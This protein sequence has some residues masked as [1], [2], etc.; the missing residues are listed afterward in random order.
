MADYYWVGDSG[1]WSDYTNHWS[2]TSGG[3]PAIYGNPPTLAD[4][5]IFDANSFGSAN[6][7]VN[8]DADSF[9][10]VVRADSV[11]DN[12]TFA[13]TGTFY[14]GSAGQAELTLGTHGWDYTGDIYFVSTGG[15]L[16]SAGNTVNNAI[17]VGVSGT[18]AELTL[19]DNINVGYLTLQEGVLEFNNKNVTALGLGVS[20]TF[21]TMNFGSGTVNTDYVQANPGTVE[22]NLGT[23]N[24]TVT[25]GSVSTG[26]SMGLDANGTLNSGSSNVYLTGDGVLFAGGSQTY[27][28]IYFSGSAIITGANTFNYLELGAGKTYD[29]EAEKT[30]TLNTVSFDGSGTADETVIRSY[31]PDTQFTFSKSSGTIEAQYVNLKDSNATGGALFIARDSTDSGNNSGWGFGGFNTALVATLGMADSINYTTFSYRGLTL[32]K[33]PHIGKIINLQPKVGRKYTYRTRS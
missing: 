14:L 7:T 18:P 9:A 16:T 5:A 22:I 17:Y 25:G 33:K 12:P 24:I 29:F 15:A 1:D 4:W 28:N 27:N 8:I 13:G 23:A 3:S 32:G 6:G 21:G 19:Q 30:Q 11:T 2:D 26:W 31:T 10:Q 20:A